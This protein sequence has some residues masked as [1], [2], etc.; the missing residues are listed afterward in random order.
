MIQ[1]VWVLLMLTG[2][3]LA[4]PAWVN[5]AIHYGKKA[6]TEKE[7][8][9]LT[10]HNE[11]SVTISKKGDA[12]ILLRVANRI[13]TKDG[14]NWGTFKS[15]E[16]PFYKIKSM[17]GWAVR[18]NG[19]VETLSKENI[20]K[21]GMT[22]SSG[23]YDDE[24]S[25]VAV[26]PN[27]QPGD[28]AAFEVEAEEKGWTTQFNSFTF[29]SQQPVVT[30]FLSV[31][32]PESWD[33]N[34]AEWNLSDVVFSQTENRY[35]WKLK[36]LAY[37]PDEPLSP[38]WYY[39]NR[40]IS[41]TCF[42][43][44]GIDETHFQDWQSVAGWMEEAYRQPAFASENIRQKTLEITEGLGTVREKIQA[45]ANFCQ[46]DIRYVAVEIGKGRWQPRLAEQTLYN[47]FGDC[48]DKTTL[49]RA[50]LAALDIPSA[51]VLA[52]INTAVNP[53]LPSPFQFDHC[54]LGIPDETAE[55][56]ASYSD[57]TVENWLFFDPTDETTPLGEIPWTLRGRHVLVGQ[58]IA[59]SSTL[60]KLPYPDPEN[61]RRWQTARATVSPDGDL[62]ADIRIVDFSG[63]SAFTKYELRNSSETELIEIWQNRFGS[64]ISGGTISNWQSGFAADSAWVSFTLSAKGYLQHSGDYLLLPAN[65][66]EYSDIPKLK[67]EKRH[68]SIWMGSPKRTDSFIEW[69]LPESWQIDIDSS[70]HFEDL[71]AATVFSQMQKTAN[72]F[73]IETGYRTHGILLPPDEYSA[74]RKLLKKHQFIKGL[75]ILIKQ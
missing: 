48:K 71:P 73:S 36:D 64:N 68:H 39:L 67:N 32:L 11:M 57:A 42:D 17:K 54:I 33:I 62:S 4:Q 18:K 2:A 35:V 65:F 16:S 66:L 13:L 25:Q 31:E 30:A 50:M 51:P 55:L 58:Q 24:Y 34:A 19:D 43:T 3:I 60:I 29:Q 46:N 59:D 28:V 20:I 69:Q 53:A 22:E 9:V 7:A 49:M 10:L 52:G 23:Y 74:V 12:K 63:W 1:L 26:L 70:Y 41:F 5:S 72:G 75:T 56:Q 6:S 37:Q 38:P 8:S 21:I 44:L 14:T 15:P 27:I 47:R 40:R 45:I 61:F